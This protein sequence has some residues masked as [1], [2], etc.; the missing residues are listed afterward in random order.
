VNAGRGR[1]PHGARGAVLVETALVVGVILTMLLFSI[2]IGVLGFLQITVDAASFVDARWATVGVKDT[3]PGAHANSTSA[4]FTQVAPNQIV[5][6]VAPAPSPSVPV[7]YG[8]NDPNA[9]LQAASLTNRHGGASMMLPTQQISTV[10]VPSVLSLFGKR[11]GAASQ[12]VDALWLEC[13]I[14]VNVSNGNAACS[15]AATGAGSAA[16]SGNYFSAG[17]DAPPYFVGLTHIHHCTDN[18]PW[19]LCSTNGTNFLA[20]GSAEFLHAP[21]G[22]Q[23]GNW[24]NALP[25][26]GGVANA[27][28]FWLMACHQR[29]YAIIAAAIVPYPTLTQYYNA[30]SS[31]AATNGYG[32]AIPNAEAIYYQMH[33]FDGVWPN[34]IGAT[35]TASSRGMTSFATGPPNLSG[36]VID[37]DSYTDTYVGRVY[38]WDTQVAAGAQPGTV[39]SNATHPESYCYYP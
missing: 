39:G 13:G 34:T 36:W 19:T 24:T 30:Y 35:S 14:H 29:T 18:Q 2:Q 10:T 33:N 7:D 17:E 16:F 4:I 38:S 11:V 1:V 22:S 9:A 23:A 27:T 15:P 32:T 25:G 3:T 5:S 20:E 12:S 6:T 21:A 28:T 31:W 37:W 26:A 8:Y